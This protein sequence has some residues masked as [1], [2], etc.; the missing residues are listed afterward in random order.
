[1]SQDSHKRTIRDYLKR[2]Q[3]QDAI[4]YIKDAYKV[5]EVEA[6]KL[7]QTLAS[8]K[9]QKEIPAH[10]GTIPPSSSAAGCAG[11]FGVLLKLISVFF[12]FTSLCMFIG[13][14]LIHFIIAQETEILEEVEA[15]I[16]DLREMQPAQM[17]PVVE[18]TWEE[19]P[20]TDVMDFSSEID[21]FTI[22]ENVF[23]LIDPRHPEEAYFEE[24][25]TASFAKTFITGGTDDMN[26]HQILDL[27]KNGITFI[28]LIPGIFFLI[29]SIVIWQISRK[30]LRK[31]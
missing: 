13:V 2:G 6:L 19:K 10:S 18:Y 23:I 17:Y 1:M 16:I 29:L 26:D 21:Q 7:I 25:L 22:G 24:D 31:T 5:S 9:S 11:C 28:L 3:R 12:I 15:T 8:E 30:L 14:G 27:I 4:E 20:Y